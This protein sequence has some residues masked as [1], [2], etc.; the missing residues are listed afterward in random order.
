LSKIAESKHW[1]VPAAPAS[2]PP[3]AGTASGDFDAKWTAEMIAGHERSVALYRAQAR[4]GED[5]DLRK[6]ARET[7]PTIER[8]L[9]ELKRL[10]K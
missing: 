10:Q 9:A 8:H 1:P 4:A 2:G 5:Q 3:P 7:L 6:Y